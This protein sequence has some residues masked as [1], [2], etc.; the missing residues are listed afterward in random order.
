MVS[1]HP[2]TREAER[3]RSLG[4]W[5]P[6]SLVNLMSFKLV[7]DRASKEMKKT[8]GSLL[9]SKNAH[10]YVHAYIKYSLV[11]SDKQPFAAK[12]KQTL[13]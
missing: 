10:K 13:S 2:D 3:R 7:V 4:L 9:V 5:W 6:G 1:T 12:R 8:Q 11:Y